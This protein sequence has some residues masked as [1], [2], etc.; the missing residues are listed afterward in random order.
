M[1]TIKYTSI[2]VLFLTSFLG[3]SQ[4]CTL[5]IGGGNSE[6]LTSVFQLNANQVAKLESLQGEYVI[7][8]KALQEEMDGLLSK[9]PQSTPEELTTLGEKYSVLEQ[10]L[11]AVSKAADKEFLQIFNENQYNRYLELCREAM[12]KP[13]FIKPIIYNDSIVPK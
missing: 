4:D 6:I 8:A 7:K 10:N 2:I 3:L 9:H 13:I 11:V 12:R 5:N 1:K